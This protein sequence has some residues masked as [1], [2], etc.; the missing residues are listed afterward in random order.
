VGVKHV[1]VPAQELEAAEDTAFMVIRDKVR[2]GGAFGVVVWSS[3]LK[4]PEST[5]ESL[6][7]YWLNGR[8]W[9]TG[10]VIHQTRPLLSGGWSGACLH[11]TGCAEGMLWDAACLSRWVSQED[12]GG[13]ERADDG[14][15]HGGQG[16]G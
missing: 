4:P 10:L 6:R 3:M 2:W 11:T 14:G 16:R 7:D 8:H 1:G 9:D 15:G 12:G 5:G 13:R